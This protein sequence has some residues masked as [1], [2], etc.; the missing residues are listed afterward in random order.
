M[1]Y[2]FDG[3]MYHVNGETLNL[4]VTPNHRMW[5]TKPQT[6]NEPNHDFQ[7]VRADAVYGKYVRYKKDAINHNQDYL[8]TLPA[9]TEFNT[10]RFDVFLQ[11]FGFFIAIG[12][13]ANDKIYLYLD[14]QRTWMTKM[15][16]IL[17]KL[18]YPWTYSDQCFIIQNKQL[19]S[20]LKTFKFTKRLPQW[21][22]NLS[23]RQARIL[24]DGL[25]TG[26]GHTTKEYMIYF[27]TLINLRD[28][29]QR[30]CFHAEWCC[31]YQLKYQT[32]QFNLWACNVRFQTD[33]TEHT[34]IEEWLPYKGKV[35]CVTVPSGIFYTRRKGKTVWTGN[36]RH[37][38]KGT[39]GI[40]FRQEDLPFTSQGIVP[41]LIVNP[42]A[43]PSRMTIGHLLECL[44]GKV[45]VMNGIGDA[46]PFS[47]H[48]EE[49]RVDLISSALKEKGF[50]KHG[51]EVM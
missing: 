22:W 47:H 12:W 34:G 38:Q 14:N 42:H 17:D 27:T 43:I 33:R 50:Q 40:T 3:E 20:Y 48:K 31:D 21:T 35:W 16:N 5:C 23:K 13:C 4:L 10:E 15:Q 32:N 8:F 49:T 25:V 7:F 2:D 26:G 37:G 51:E 9:T 11:Y 44:L 18:E 39:I 28:D 46:T 1:Q 41:D 6:K 30:L 24:L 36:S 29:F 19:Y 45:S